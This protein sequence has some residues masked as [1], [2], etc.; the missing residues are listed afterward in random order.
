MK[1]LNFIVYKVIMK[2]YNVLNTEI[3]T[4]ML[5]PGISVLFFFLDKACVLLCI[6]RI[7]LSDNT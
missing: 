6:G 1:I 2:I 4:L 3:V 7:I 5:Q